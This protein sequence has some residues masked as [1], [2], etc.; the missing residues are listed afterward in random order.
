MKSGNAS[1][2][3]CKIVLTPNDVTSKETS[4]V[5]LYTQQFGQVG[6][7]NE[8]I[9]EREISIT[10]GVETIVK[11]VPC[12]GTYSG[13]GVSEVTYAMD[14]VKSTTNVQQE[15]Q[16]EPSET[17]ST[18]VIEPTTSTETTTSAETTNT[19]ENIVTP[20]EEKKDEASSNET[21]SDK[22]KSDELTEDIT[23]STNTT[24]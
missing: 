12:W 19:S 13:E 10:V 21:E 7:Q 16:S 6:G 1:T 23:T 3:Y 8:T 5:V 4:E 11:F 20:T 2:G 22:V 14:A 9:N 15:I 17:P 18:T 24:E